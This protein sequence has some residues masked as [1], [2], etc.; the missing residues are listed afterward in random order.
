MTF[1]PP[2]TT[3]SDILINFT[4]GPG[5]GAGLLTWTTDLEFDL[6]G[7]NVVTLDA[8]GS[9]VQLNSVVIPCEECITV[10]GHTY[11]FLVPMHKSGRN[12]YIEVV[13]VDHKVDV[14]GPSRR[15]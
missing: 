2:L 10:G 7:F 12:I 15:E 3:V 6:L 4:S 11:T 14:F 13:H 5:K 1:R 8:R 9:R